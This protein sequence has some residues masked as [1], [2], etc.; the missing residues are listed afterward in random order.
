[1]LTRGK[2]L[3]AALV[4]FLFVAGASPVKALARD[5][6]DRRCEQQIRN[7]ENKLHNAERRHGEHSRQAE[8]RR[9]QLEEVR[10]RC[11]RHDRDHDHH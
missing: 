10:E 3:V 2:T 7:A 9:H 1:M 4:I 5:R 11:R 8:Q 6:D